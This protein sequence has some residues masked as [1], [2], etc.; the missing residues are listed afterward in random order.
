[1][2]GLK[3]QDYESLVLV[4]KAMVFVKGWGLRDFWL[5]E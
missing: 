3:S 4:S 2:G 5:S 1:M